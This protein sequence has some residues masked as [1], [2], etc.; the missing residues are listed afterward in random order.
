MRS[1]QEALHARREEAARSTRHGLDFEDAVGA[2]LA[3]ATRNSGI[4]ESVGHTAGRI[5]RCKIG[6][7]V[8]AL[9]PENAAPGA[10]IVFEAK[11]DPRYDLARSLE[12][13]AQARDNR[14]AQVGV[15]VLSRATA[16]EEMERFVRIGS[17][18]V[19]IWDRD[20]A[21]RDS[22]V[23]AA[24]SL[25]RA[26]VVR[27]RTQQAR[28]QAEFTAIEAAVLRI[29]KAAEIVTLAGAS[30]PTAKRSATAPSGPKARSTN[31]LRG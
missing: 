13:L 25:A 8:L 15:A 31:S 9:G 20:D 17:D 4:L 23:T 22:L 24:V 3:D 26:R 12:K 16:P 19:V 27:E 1:T 28:V 21:T 14:G 11:E 10:P 5:P 6:D 30:A 7:F 2:L 18:I 29:A